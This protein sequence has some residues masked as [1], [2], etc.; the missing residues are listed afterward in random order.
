VMLRLVLRT[1][2]DEA[3]GEEV[4]DEVGAEGFR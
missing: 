3:G 1:L 4:A 2:E